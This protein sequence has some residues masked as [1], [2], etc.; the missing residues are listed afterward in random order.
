MSNSILFI[1]ANVAD[2]AAL[3]AEELDIKTVS[4]ITGLTEEIILQ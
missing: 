1:D 3:L 4:K 2:Y